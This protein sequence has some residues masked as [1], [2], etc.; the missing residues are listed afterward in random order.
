LEKPED[1]NFEWFKNANSIGICGAT[2]T[3][4]WLMEDVKKAIDSK[5]SVLQEIGT[6]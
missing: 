6:I 2:S 5:A 4:M 1:I 3:P